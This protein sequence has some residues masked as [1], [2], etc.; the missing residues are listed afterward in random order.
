MRGERR[1]RGGGGVIVDRVRGGVSDGGMGT[2]RSATAGRAPTTR[3]STSTRSTE[4]LV[5]SR[6]QR[7]TVHPVWAASWWASCV[8]WGVESSYSPLLSQEETKKIY[9]PWFLS[10]NGNVI[11]SVGNITL[12]S[13]LTILLNKISCF[14]LPISF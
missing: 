14:V 5:A 12:R 7:R 6:R 9:R 1:A 3:R 2:V 11:G 13:N 8:K 10:P 4:R